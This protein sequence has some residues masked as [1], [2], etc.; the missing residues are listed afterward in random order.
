MSGV[1][2]TAYRLG[3]LLFAAFIFFGAVLFP[4]LDLNASAADEASLKCQESYMSVC[5]QDV[6]NLRPTS[7]MEKEME[8]KV[9]N[10]NDKQD[11]WL[12]SV[13]GWVFTVIIFALG[14]LHIFCPDVV[15]EIRFLGRNL[16]NVWTK[17]DSVTWSFRY[18]RT[19]SSGAPGVID[20]IV[21]SILIICS[22]VMAAVLLFG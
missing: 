21:G 8:E 17:W 7:E 15:T 16:F 10:T 2:S 9:E 14:L 22:L 11:D 3:C 6:A 4:H 5:R 18:H 19:E 12:G 13:F 1:K 20:Y